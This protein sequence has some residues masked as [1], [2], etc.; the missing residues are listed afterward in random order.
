MSTARVHQAKVQSYLRH[1]DDE[2]DAGAAQRAANYGELVRHYYDLATD[3]YE[4]G[5]GQSFHF[6]P[7]AAG[8]SFGASLA[9]H[10]RRLAETLR[11]RSGMR[12]LDLGCGVG[13]PMR[14]IARH[15][16]AYVVGVNLNPYQVERTRAHN[17]KAGL[18]HLCTA[19]EADFMKLPFEDG[20]FDAAYAIEATCHAPDRAALFS[21]VARVLRPGA[22]IAG[23]EW[24][25]TDRYV[26]SDPEHRRAKRLIEEGDGLPDLVH[27]KEIDRALGEAGMDVLTA[28]DISAEGDPST[29]WYHPLAGTERS[30]SGFRR[31]PVGR[32]LTEAMTRV[33]EKARIA[34]PGSTEVSQLLQRAADG[35]VRG[36]ELG[37]FTPMYFFHARKP[38]A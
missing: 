6:A 12:V 20:S 19:V 5:W 13:G 24:C 10:E 15:S 29:P 25:M 32:K 9:R 16:G 38:A 23:Y 4:F 34:P 8:E 21:E 18:S 22:E 27:V 31:R 26:A 36:G 17:A 2:G 11:L 3:F 1:Y 28:D 33:L 7:R 35:L 37:I 14:E 30:L